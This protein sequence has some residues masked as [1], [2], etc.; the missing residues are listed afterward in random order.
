MQ[1]FSL[2]E[3]K[4]AFYCLRKI[5]IV[6]SKKQISL[7]TQT[8]RSRSQPIGH[9]KLKGLTV[10]MEKSLPKLVDPMSLQLILM[11]NRDKAAII[12]DHEIKTKCK[13]I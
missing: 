5:Q 7:N 6:R 2:T 4:R 1:I 12:Y 10:F 8:L 9:A 3:S 13:T 11:K